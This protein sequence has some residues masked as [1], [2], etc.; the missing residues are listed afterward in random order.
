MVNG[1]DFAVHLIPNVDSAENPL[2]VVG[3][4]SKSQTTSCRTVKEPVR[5]LG[6]L[7]LATTMSRII[8]SFPEQTSLHLPSH[9]REGPCRHMAYTW[10]LKELCV[11]E[12]A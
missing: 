4:G 5:V 8:L 12:F 3:S 7:G 2:V 11:W 10:A 1:P 6:L 9:N